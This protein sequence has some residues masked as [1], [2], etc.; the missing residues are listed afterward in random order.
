MSKPISSFSQP[1]GPQPSGVKPLVCCR[2]KETALKAT[3]VALALLCLGG[4]LVVGMWGQHFLPEMVALEIPRLI[5]AST[6]GLVGLG[7]GV[8]VIVASVKCASVLE[9]A[10]GSIEVKPQLLSGASKRTTVP[11]MRTQSL[12][13]PGI[14]E[15]LYTYRTAEGG[16]LAAMT[17]PRILGKLREKVEDQPGEITSLVL[18]S[19]LFDASV[20]DQFFCYWTPL[21]TFQQK[22]LFWFMGLEKSG[23]RIEGF[24]F[25]IQ[26]RPKAVLPD[27]FT[28][29]VEGPIRIWDRDGSLLLALPF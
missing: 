11:Q 22:R 1:L 7:I 21:L 2:C 17:C 3:L 8:E 26:D 25:Q 23:S 6:F 5:V 4:G 12:E 13:E 20:S 24:D 9:V 28:T 14:Q 19:E 27:F 16:I 18:F 29:K 15:K 10:G